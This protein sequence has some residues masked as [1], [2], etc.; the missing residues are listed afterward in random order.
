MKLE[1]IITRQ[2]NNLKTVEANIC[3]FFFTFQ[4]TTGI[5]VIID[6]LR[7][8]YTLYIHIFRT[9]WSYREEHAFVWSHPIW[10]RVF[11]AEAPALEPDAEVSRLIQ[12]VMGA[13][14][15]VTMNSSK[16]FSLW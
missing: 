12:V 2:Y 13:S 7:H 4:R 3:M 1:H 9:V 6:I 11:R 8:L 5:H 14:E 10:A 15:K 16:Q